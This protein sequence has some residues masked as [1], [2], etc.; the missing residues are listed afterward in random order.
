MHCVASGARGRVEK[1]ESAG[2]AP[3]RSK[4]SPPDGGTARLRGSSYSVPSIR[5]QQPNPS[6]PTNYNGL[7][8]IFQSPAAWQNPYLQGSAALH[9][10][11]MLDDFKEFPSWPEPIEAQVPGAMRQMGTDSGAESHAKRAAVRLNSLAAARA[12]PRPPPRPSAPVLPQART[13]FRGRRT[14]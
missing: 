14:A 3:K 10:L 9:G 6:V 11:P 13:P 8:S 4:P 12:L 2:R 1:P 7:Q 5:S